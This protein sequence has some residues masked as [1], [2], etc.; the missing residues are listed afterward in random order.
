M[1]VV[2][3]YGGWL[4]WMDVGMVAWGM[5]VVDGGYFLHLTIA[6]Q[7][8]RR[9]AFSSI[10]SFSSVTLFVTLSLHFLSE[11]LADTKLFISEQYFS[12]Y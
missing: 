6:K 4:W 9:A 5:V 11:K 10:R 7:Q 8:D 2:D 1:V 12:G 3:C